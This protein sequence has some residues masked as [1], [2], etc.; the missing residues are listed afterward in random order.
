MIYTDISKNQRIDMEKCE[1]QV[2]LEFMQT[3]PAKKSPK[4]DAVSMQ[5]R[6]EGNHLLVESGDLDGEILK[7]NKAILVAEARSENMGICYANRA[8]CLMRL[9]KYSLCLGDIELAKR[10][11]YPFRLFAKLDERKAKCLSSMRESEG[12]KEKKGAEAKLRFAP[13]EKKAYFANGIEVTH[14]QYGDCHI[15]TKRNLEIGQTIIVEEPYEFIHEYPYDYRQCANCFKCDVNLIPCR[16]CIVVM[17]CSQECYDE[18]HEKF[19]NIECGVIHRFTLWEPFR[20]LVFRTIIL[21]IKTFGTVQALM[22]AI[23][24]FNKEKKIDDT[25]AA[26]RNYFEFFVARQDFV[27]RPREQEYR[28]LVFHSYI[29]RVITKESNL[30]TMFS[31]RKYQRFL[32]HLILHHLYVL[33]RNVVIANN[34]AEHTYRAELGVF[35]FRLGKVFGHGIALDGM[36][37]RHSC[38]PNVA[39]I[40][41]GKQIIYKVIR[42]IQSGEELFVPYMYVCF[43]CS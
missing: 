16:K 37:I 4:I 14:S 21:A 28:I 11:G 41:V 10:N 35:H 9:K 38:V 27:N 3:E 42:P 30:K 31:S 34:F 39:R 26:K 33:N 5:I 36:H 19:H 7:F 2:H 15:V 24:L 20:R 43:H 22:D 6:N 13:N 8:A 25:N 12:V 32:G 29:Q 17:F 40:F 1:I 23:D 18:G